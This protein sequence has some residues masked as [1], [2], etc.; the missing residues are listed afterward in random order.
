MEYCEG[1]VVRVMTYKES[2]VIMTVFTREHGLI[3]VLAKGAKKMKSR[4]R[5][6]A[7][8]FT[9]ASF[10]VNYK[11]NSLSILTD[12]KLIDANSALKVDL[13][14][15]AYASYLCELTFKV[16]DKDDIQE[17]YFQLLLDII[18]KLNI[19]F[20]PKIMTM[21][22][23]LKLLDYLGVR[24]NL[25]SCANCFTKQKIVSFDAKSGGYICANCFG[26]Y[27][28]RVSIKSIKVLR[29]LFYVDVKK[30]NSIKLNLNTINEIKFFI[31]DYY[32]SNTGLYLKSKKFLRDIEKL[33]IT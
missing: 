12:L 26:P 32:E 8:I 2:D 17:D 19:D 16:F 1:L 20:N 22:Y 30:V 25:D 31:N 33:K 24:P 15:A 5:S 9:H 18:E 6:S 10:Y 14:K 23:E 11:P 3:S 27:M 13:E 7:S 4:F 29:Q 28:K 21:I